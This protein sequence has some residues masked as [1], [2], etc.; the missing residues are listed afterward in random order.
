MKFSVGTVLAFAAAV[1]AK[2]ILLNSNYQVEEGKP[3]TLQWSNAQGPVTIT[4]MTGDPSDLKEVTTITCKEAPR[5][6]LL[7]PWASTSVAN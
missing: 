7:L 2:P 5:R 3:F 1:L 4:L 6:F